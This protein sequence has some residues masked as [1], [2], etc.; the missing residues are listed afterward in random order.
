[1]RRSWSGVSWYSK[2]CKILNIHLAGSEPSNRGTS[3]FK[4]W[5]VL[6]LVVGVGL[7]AGEGPWGLVY[8]VSNWVILWSSSSNLEDIDDESLAKASSHRSV[9]VFERVTSAMATTMKAPMLGL[10]GPATSLR[11]K[12]E[13]REEKE[14]RE[15]QRSI[16]IF[17]SFCKV[18]S[19]IYSLLQGTKLNGYNRKS[20]C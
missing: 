16:L 14:E 20:N 9:L 2:N 5:T 11:K 4:W 12:R 17:L 19:V 1:M 18:L 7:N 6:M 15:R 3:S 13:E 8:D 10:Q